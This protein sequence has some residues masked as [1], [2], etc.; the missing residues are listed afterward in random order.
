MAV[1]RSEVPRPY[2][3]GA[4][5]VKLLTGVFVGPL[6]WGLNLEI[7]YSLVKWACRSDNPQVLPILSAAALV[8]VAGGLALSW[9]CLTQLRAEGDPKGGRVVDRSYFLAAAGIGVS[10]LCALLIVTGGALH[11][12]V[13]PCE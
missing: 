11:F 3:D 8:L 1:M 13:G 6:A 9:G 10:A 4:G 12:I 7:N 2:W 5:L